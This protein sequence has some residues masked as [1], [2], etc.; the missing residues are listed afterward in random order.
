MSNTELDT[1]EARDK[2]ALVKYICDYIDHERASYYDIEW[3]HEIDTWIAE[4]IE[5]FESIHDV[6]VCVMPVVWRY[7]DG[8]G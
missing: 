8:K 6:K 1:K 7:S 4:G 3:I 5:A 2:K